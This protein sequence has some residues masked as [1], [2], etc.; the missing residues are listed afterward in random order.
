MR[1]NMLADTVKH[2]ILPLNS[3]GVM[4]INRSRSRQ[5]IRIKTTEKCP[6]CYGTGIVQSS[7]LFIDLLETWITKETK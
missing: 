2:E 7:I 1:K 5:E 4:Q 3:F 6:T